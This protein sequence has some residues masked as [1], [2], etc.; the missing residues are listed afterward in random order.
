M[1]LATYLKEATPLGIEKGFLIIGFSKTAVFFKEALAHKDNMGLL[2]KAL[3]SVCGVSLRV[4]LEIVE[5]L[6]SARDKE[7][8]VEETP[9]LRSAL[10]LFKGKVI[11]RT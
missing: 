6:L 9:F 2:E 11:K 3:N 5:G 10:D 1:S 4:K 8:V 7:E